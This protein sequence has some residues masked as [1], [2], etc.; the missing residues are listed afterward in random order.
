M[1]YTRDTELPVIT[2]AASTAVNCNPTQAE[3][4]AA[5]GAATVSDNCSIG[6]VA[7]GTVGAESGSGCTYTTTKTW[8]V[9]D[10]C[11]NVGTASQTVTYTRDTELPVITLAASTAV[12]CNPTQAEIDAAFGTATV[13]DNCSVGLT[14]T[15]VVRN[16]VW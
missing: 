9:T 1:T 5:F 11:G 14:A 10:A 8:T 6:L 16:R 3:I 4:D 13:S 15:G 12:N 2:L 7:T